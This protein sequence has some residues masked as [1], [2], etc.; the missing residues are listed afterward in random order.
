MGFMFNGASEF[1]GDI[2]NWDV[3][4][5]SQMSFMFGAASSFN[6]DLSNWIVSNVICC[7][8]FSTEASN[9]SLLKPNF[10]NCKE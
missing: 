9:W 5:V 7:S 6:Q 1:N 10:T 4:N 8:G 2:S 3:S